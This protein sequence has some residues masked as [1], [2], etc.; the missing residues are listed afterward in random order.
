VARYEV[1]RDGRLV[2]RT[3][4]ATPFGLEAG[5]DASSD[6]CFTVVAVDAA[7]NRSAA[8]G[9]ACARTTEPGVP[10]GPTALAI[11]PRSPTLALLR[12]QPSPDPGVVYAVYWGDG[13]KRIGATP[14]TEYT[15]AGLKV[16]ERRCFRVAAVDPAG[17]ESPASLEACT[18]TMPPVQSASAT[19]PR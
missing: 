4:A 3:D 13:R 7:G 9:P 6:Y 11:A 19:E 18:S 2:A 16:G 14:R 1:L 5:L 8:A 12:W 17:Q 10:A 15:V